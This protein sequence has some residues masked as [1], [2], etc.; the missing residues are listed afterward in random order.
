MAAVKPSDFVLYRRLL[1]QTRPYWPHI[2]GIF[3]IDL[4][5]TPLALLGPHPTQDCR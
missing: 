3:L 1:Q 5:A 4:L 2:V